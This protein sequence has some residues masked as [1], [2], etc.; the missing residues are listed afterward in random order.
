MRQGPTRTN[1]EGIRVD[2][3]APE[4]VVNILASPLSTKQIGR[5]CHRLGMIS[6]C[7]CVFAYAR[8]ASGT[9]WVVGCDRVSPSFPLQS[10]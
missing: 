3:R 5:I 10:R 4:D 1:T 8:G 9:V 2:R 6:V 7:M